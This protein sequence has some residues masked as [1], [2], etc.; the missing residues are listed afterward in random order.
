[1]LVHSWKAVALEDIYYEYNSSICYSTI[2]GALEYI[3]EEE[4]KFH[5]EFRDKTFFDFLKA[6]NAGEVDLS[7]TDGK[8]FWTIQHHEI[9]V[10]ELK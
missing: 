9:D 4:Y 7:I 3:F 6:Y 5:K 10:T 8:H 2:N 1:M